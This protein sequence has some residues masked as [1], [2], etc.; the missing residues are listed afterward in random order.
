MSVQVNLSAEAKASLPRHV[1]IIMDGNGRWAK[2][3]SLPRVEGHRQGAESARTII[4]TSGELGIK[5]LTLYAF[6]AENWNRPKEEVDT[7]MQYLARFLKSEI[8][9]LN[10]I[11][12]AYLDLAENRAERGILTKMTDWVSFLNKFLELSNYPIL[13]DKGKMS[14]LEAKL[15]AEGEY[16]VYRKR[17]D[18]EYISDFDREIKRI[19]GRK[20]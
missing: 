1:A 7:L 11:V 13:Q 18:V 17:Q 8:A 2:Q 19:E 15:K 3:R 4:R 12:S 16:E 9:E 5:Y 6:S 20:P 14:A 10:R